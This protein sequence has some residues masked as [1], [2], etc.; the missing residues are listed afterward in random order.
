M[1]V[2]GDNSIGNCLL[3]QNRKNGPRMRSMS[4]MAPI[5]MNKKILNDNRFLRNLSVVQFG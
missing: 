5:A 4:I 1:L 2:I 3:P